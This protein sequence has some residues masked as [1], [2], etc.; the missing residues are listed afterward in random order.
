MRTMLQTIFR[1]RELTSS[2]CIEEGEKKG[3]QFRAL[4]RMQ[5]KLD[6]TRTHH[7]GLNT[8]GE[9][10]LSAPKKHTHPSHSSVKTAYMIHK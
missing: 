7:F 8:E 9:I 10:G 3:E 5:L 1:S 2:G 4:S 6:A